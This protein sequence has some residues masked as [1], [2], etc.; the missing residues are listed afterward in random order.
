MNQAG[1][2]NAV[3]CSKCFINQGLKLEAERIG[4][5][6]DGACPHCTA[7]DGKK[8]DKDLVETL[9]F[10]FFVR[11]TYQS[12]VTP[13]CLSFF[14]QFRWSAS[15]LVIS[16]CIPTLIAEDYHH[17]SADAGGARQPAI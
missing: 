5:E 14:A 15:G 8:L 11:G 13:Q 3:L 7:T 2:I 10:R 12:R 9:A 4:V 16:R 1:Q 17:Q 6:Q